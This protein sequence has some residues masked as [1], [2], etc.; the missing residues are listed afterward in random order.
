MSAKA[1]QHEIF[2]H[3]GSLIEKSQSPSRFYNTTTVFNPQGEL[4]ATYRKVHLFDINVPGQVTETESSTIIQG[5]NLVT[6]RLPWFCLGLSI[7][8]D[9]RFPEIYRALACAGAQVFVIPSVFARTTGEAH[10]HI[11]LRARAI[12]NHAYILAASQFGTDIE[13]HGFYGHSMI[14]DPWGV[15][16][17]EAPAEDEAVLVADIDVDQVNQR[18][19]QI[20][21][22]DVRRPE[23]YSRIERR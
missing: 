16:V 9:V 21:V 18:R 12:E 3:A 15:I 13:G 10:W 8:F 2:L 6:V 5:E 4:I 1:R 23:V 7:C 17:A 22:L 20:P 11:L 14:V 19:S